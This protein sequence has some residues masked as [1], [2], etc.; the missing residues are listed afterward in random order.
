MRL[1]LLRLTVLKR[2]VLYDGDTSCA[3]VMIHASG[4]AEHSV[5]WKRRQHKAAGC[6]K[7]AINWPPWCGLSCATLVNGRGGRLPIAQPP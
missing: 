3:L 6:L 5:M 7:H 4:T 2:L 1:L